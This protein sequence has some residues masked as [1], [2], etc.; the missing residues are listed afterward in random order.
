MVVPRMQ[1]GPLPSRAVL[2]RPGQP[3]EQPAHPRFAQAAMSGSGP[4]ASPVGWNT[5][6]VAPI[7]AN[8]AMDSSMRATRS[9]PAGRPRRIAL[10]GHMIVN[11]SHG[12]GVEDTLG[13]AV[14]EME[15]AHRPL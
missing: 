15:Q 12:G 14:T 13:A 5:T 3:E 1:A 2:A 10:A 8:V 9:D 6:V 7:S 11:S 4:G